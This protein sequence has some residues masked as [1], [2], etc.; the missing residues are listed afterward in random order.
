MA[1]SHVDAHT[2][3]ANAAKKVRSASS[4]AKVRRRGFMKGNNT[5]RERRVEDG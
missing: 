2:C 4:A 5:A 1:P 3:S